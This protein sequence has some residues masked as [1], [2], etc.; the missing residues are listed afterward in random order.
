M[1]RARK[2]SNNSV[3]LNFVEILEQ[4]VIEVIIRCREVRASETERD[5]E[6][7]ERVY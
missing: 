3:Q 5:R 6:K 4:K 7:P 2:L 1:K